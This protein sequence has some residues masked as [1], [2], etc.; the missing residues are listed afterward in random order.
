MLHFYFSRSC[1]DLKELPPNKPLLDINTIVM[2]QQK[3]KEYTKKNQ[4][5]FEIPQDVI[6]ILIIEKSY[7]SKI[8]IK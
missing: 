1:T 4:L 7:P 3:K 6:F 2:Q 5:P 8:V